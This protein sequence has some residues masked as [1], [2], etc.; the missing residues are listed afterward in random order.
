[1][2][3]NGLDKPLI[4]VAVDWVD[5]AKT[6]EYENFTSLE[7]IRLGDTI[8]CDLDD[9]KFQ[10]RVIATT[11]DV[12]L[13]RI[14]SF[15]IG[16]PVATLATSMNATIREVESQDTSSLLEQ[17]QENAS[18]MLKNAMTGY[19]YFDYDNGNLY[20]MDN[21]DPD[22]AVKVWRW[23]LNGLGYSST[24]INGTYGLAITM[25]G[26]I[27]ADYI[28]TGHLNTNVI[29]G[30]DSLVA[31]VDELVDLM[32]TEEGT[33]SI[34]LDGAAK[35]VIHRLEITGQ[36]SKIFPSDSVKTGIVPYQNSVPYPSTT[37]YPKDTYLRVD[38]TDYHLDL[39][40]LNY[41]S[42]T[43]HDIYIVDSGK[44][45]I[46]RYVGIDAN[47]DMYE[48]PTPIIEQKEDLYIDIDEYSTITL[49]SF[50]S[51]NLKAEYMKQNEYTELEKQLFDGGGT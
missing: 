30:Y 34:Q 12:L 33:G 19:I 7:T 18:N 20:I 17:A 48:L 32:K 51:A 10:T 45:W 9:F 46:E 31:S 28:T 27:V 3:N 36:I 4:N 16:Q 5:L 42:E 21:P 40:F 15:Q 24:G 23:N 35:G 6:K 22:D 1:M 47:G 49:L 11:Y 2:F 25:D 41:M 44:Q 39:N 8:T 29:Q 43:I 38:S 50:P 14:T 13:D 26:S 37:L